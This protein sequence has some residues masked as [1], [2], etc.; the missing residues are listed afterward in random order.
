MKLEIDTYDGS[1]IY[2]I[3]P[4]ARESM[5]TEYKVVE[6]ASLTFDGRTI[7]KMYGVPETISFTVRINSKE[8]VV[9]FVDWL[10][11]KVKQKAISLRLNKRIAD[12]LDRDLLKRKMED[13]YNRILE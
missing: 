8:Q 5:H 6:G 11:P 13:E 12:H 7:S 1:L 2:D 4:I 10:F 3:F 9:N